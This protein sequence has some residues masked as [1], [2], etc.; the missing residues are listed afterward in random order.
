MLPLS[1]SIIICTHKT[2][3]YSQFIIYKI[4]RTSLQSILQIQLTRPSSYWSVTELVL[5]YFMMLFVILLTGDVKN[6]PNEL[7]IQDLYL[8]ITYII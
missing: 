2:I 5:F 7:I 6:K 4:N 1:L 8:F 3:D